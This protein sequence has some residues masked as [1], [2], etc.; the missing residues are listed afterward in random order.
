MDC[1][2]IIEE[3]E[4]EGLTIQTIEKGAILKN[5]TAT[6]SRAHRVPRD[7]E[8]EDQ[9]SEEVVREVENFENKPKSNLYETEVVNL[10][11]AETAKE[12]R[13]SIHLSPPKKEEYIRFLKEYED[14]FAW[15]YDDMTG[16]STSIVAHKLP[17]HPMCLPVK[18]K[19]KKFKQDMSLEIK[20]E[21]IK[22]IK[23][24]VIRVVEYPTWLA[25]IVP[26][27]KKDGKVRDGPPK[28]HILEAHVDYEVSQ[29]ADTVKPFCR[30]SRGRRIRTLKIDFPNEEVSFVGDVTEAYGGWRMFFDGTANFK[31]VGIGAIMVSKTSQHY[32]M[33]AKLRFPYTG[34]MAEYEAYI[35]GLNMAIDM[36]IQEQLVID[37]SDLLVHQVQGEWATKN[38]KILLY[39]HYVHELRKRFTKIEFRHVPKIQNEFVDAL[40]TLSSMIHYPDKNFIDPIPLRINNQPAYC[41][42]IEEETDGNPWFHDIKGYLAKEEYSEHVN[43][44]PK[45]T[46]Q[47]LSNHFFHSG[48]NL[49]RR[50]PDLGLLSGIDYFKKWVE[51]ASYKAVTKKVIADFLK[52]RIVYR[53]GVPE[54]IISDNATSLNSGLMKA[55]CETFK[56]KYKNSTAYRP[57]MNGAVEVANKNIIKILRKMVENHKQW[58][59]KL[60][61]AFLGYRSTVR[62]STR[63]TPYMLVYGTEAVIPAK[64]IAVGRDVGYTRNSMDW[65]ESIQKCWNE[66]LSD[67]RFIIDIQLF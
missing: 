51:P 50:T 57:Q 58:H 39:L 24:K 56:I 65:V 42:H 19:L 29:M 23:P 30:K 4:E 17:T 46:L 27:P 35:L 34:N 1:S 16:L 5:W 52:D 20:E 48:G 6:P 12:T 14:I 53:F 15:S 67:K 13:I 32:P 49:Y 7:S 21:V 63:A 18:Q 64:D 26:V 22:Q 3:E 36:N 2:A 10:G 38:S 47:R 31:G 40:A 33:S 59:E 28:V 62:T 66:A 8:E 54:S 43:H 41:A 45:C 37:D 61:F 11:D 60:P 44:T 9:I 25:N 55:M